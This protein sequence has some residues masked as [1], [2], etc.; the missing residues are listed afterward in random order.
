LGVLLWA[1]AT[2]ERLV[3]LSLLVGFCYPGAVAAPIIDLVMMRQ[4]TQRIDRLEPP[5]E[6][7][8]K[9]AQWL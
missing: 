4:V 7:M 3:P 8:G 2:F 1:F 6:V 9:D 5:D